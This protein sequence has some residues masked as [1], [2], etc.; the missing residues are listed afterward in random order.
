MTA[1]LFNDSP[2]VFIDQE[3]TLPQDDTYLL[4][5]ENTDIESVMD[6]SFRLA[7]PETV[8]VPYQLGTFVS[9]SISEPASAI[10]TRSRSRA[11]HSSL[12]KSQGMPRPRRFPGNSKVP[13]DCSL[14]RFAGVSHQAGR[15]TLQ[16]P[17]RSSP[18]RP[19]SRCRP[20]ITG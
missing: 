1:T 16:S 11:A 8:S 3:F 10:S 12:M 6:Y 13:L 15:L 17:I 18:N 4:F 7:T 5:V 2:P 9:G 14:T 19:Y 20:G